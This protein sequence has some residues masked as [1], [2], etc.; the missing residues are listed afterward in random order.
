MTRMVGIACVLLLFPLIALGDDA[1]ASDAAPSANETKHLL[2]YKFQPGENLRWNVVH[3]VKVNTTVSGTAQ[4]AE[5]TSTSV[6]LWK[7]LPAKK[8]G[9]YRFEHSVERVEMRQ[10]LTGREEIVYNSQTD[11]APPIGFE[12]A[13][14]NVGV[15]LAVIT[16]DGQGTVLDR[17]RKKSA[18]N[19]AESQ[20][21]IP[22][23]AEA[24]PAGHVWS[25]PYDVQV[26]LRSGEARMIKTRQRF[27]LESVENGIASIRVETQVLTPVQDPEIEAQ[28][29]QRETKGTVRFDIAAGRIIEQRMDL[30]K[31]VLGFSGES[32]SL[33]YVMRFTEELAPSGATASAPAGPV[34]PAPLPSAAKGSAPAKSKTAAKPA[35]QNTQAAKPSGPTAKVASPPTTG[36]KPASK[37]R[38]R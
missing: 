23:P 12:D 18:P 30:D 29:I 31:S 13:A 10:K 21:V 36:N 32:S 34:G 11:V 17:E 1:P 28:L 19:D 26:N 4:T 15:P 25:F 35:P 3:R 5:T 16:V 9:T 2:R 14:K 22:L 8:E 24:V 6:K 38:R 33:H 7:V 27:T 37:Y 20:I